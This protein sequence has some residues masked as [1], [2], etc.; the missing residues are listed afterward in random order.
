MDLKAI[1]RGHELDL[2]GSEFGQIAGSYESRIN[3]RLP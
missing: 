3:H 1:E 2:R